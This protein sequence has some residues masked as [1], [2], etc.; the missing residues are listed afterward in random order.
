MLYLHV[1]NRT[2]NLLH[3]L[4]QLFEVDLRRDLF[5]PECF[6]IQSQGMERMISQTLADHFTSFCN[7]EY[8]LPLGFLRHVAAGLDMDITP[9]GYDRKSVAWQLEEILRDLDGEVYSPL[10]NYLQGQNLELKR[11]Q[12]ADQ[13]SNVFDQYQLM[14]PQ[15]IDSWAEQRMVSSDPAERWQCALWNRLAARLGNMP[16]RGQVLGR[17]VTRLQQGDDLSHIVPQRVSVF[18]LSIMPPLFLNFLQGLARHS[19]VHLFLLSPCR[20]YWGDIESRRQV[21]L[22][23]LKN[24]ISASNFPMEIEE[25]PESHPLLI[26]LGRQGRDFQRMLLEGVDF[27]LDFD[28]YYDP[29]ED[30]EPSLLK[31]LQSDLLAGE[32]ARSDEEWPADD[33]SIRIVSSHSRLRELSILKDHIKSWLYDDSALQLRDI[34]V[35]APDIQEYAALIPSVFDDIQHSI[36]DRSLRKRN[37]VFAAFDEFLALFK[38]R[39]GWDEVMTLLK[40]PV[41]A[42]PLHLAPA[43]LEKLHDWVVRAGIRW[44]LSARQRKEMGLPE[45]GE[46]SWRVGLERLLMGYAM[47]RDEF[48]AG[49]LPFTDI[50][51]SGAA[52]L[53]G[54]CKFIDI[55]ERAQRDFSKRYTLKEWAEL[56]IHYC[57]ELFRDESERFITKEFLE[58]Q[59]VLADLADGP[60]HF[61]NSPVDFEV[62]RTW[63]D[64]TARE[65]RSSSGFLRGQ[66]TFCS[67][68]PMRSIPFKVVCLIGMNDTV[69]P[70]NDRHATF[71]LLALQHKP[72]DRSRRMDDRYQFL[73]ALLAAR[74]QLYISY[75]GQS[76]RTNEEIPP[77]VVVSELLE[78]LEDYYQR[79]NFVVRHPLHPFSRHYFSGLSGTLFSYDER[80]LQVAENLRGDRVIRSAWWSGSRDIEN[81]MIN[82]ADLLVFYANPQRWFVR[83]CLNI[84]LGSDAE[85]VDESEPFQADGLEKYLLDQEILEAILNRESLDDRFNK[86]TTTGRWPLGAPGNLEFERKRSEMESFALSISELDLGERV[87]DLDIELDVGGYHLR[88]RLTNIYEQGI[89]LC[90]YGKMRGRDVLKGWLHHLVYREVTGCFTTTYVCGSDDRRVLSG[91]SG[92]MPNLELM[93]DLFVAG[94]KS[95]SRLLVEP[96]IEWVKRL[97]KGEGMLQAALTALNRTLDNGYDAELA[98]L[99]RNSDPVDFLDSEFEE[100]CR[101]VLL[102]IWS[103]TDG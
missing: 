94:N 22:R 9:D 99:L 28:S 60:G 82:F 97:P 54:L 66:L 51:G 73:E 74:D 42:E 17:L 91:G 102:P 41:I 5:A 35:M 46:G 45:M 19:D 39:F 37:S 12:L 62:V 38:G 81:G 98:L 70:T 100:L 71:D 24:D 85:T 2:E 30:G 31:T 78:I 4:V 86:L 26:S 11:F 93:L 40:E 83:N 44:G 84:Q 92:L 80:Y 101:T 15:M 32:V 7:F 87:E 68:L 75:I 23:S 21:L 95:P 53:G 56:F 47:D 16:H 65:T 55:I 64:H 8:H 43:D 33:H 49:V 57:R 103:Q 29:L 18:G 25:T 50:E 14:R 63:L 58:L 13:L 27:D 36:S 77:S 79:R 61:H 34:V 10:I 3:H 76:I 89:L 20:E 96:G 6:L 72:G 1:S 90:R 59:E 52:S 67:M 88:G 48:V 69:F